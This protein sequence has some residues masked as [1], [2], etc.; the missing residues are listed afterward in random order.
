MTTTT[1]TTTVA[2]TPDRDRRRGRAWYALLAV[3]VVAMLWVPSYAGA[4][5]A[6]YGIPFFYWYQFAW[7]LGGALLTAAVYRLTDSEAAP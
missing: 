7:V 2:S 3:P 1:T 4:A 5:P 6:V